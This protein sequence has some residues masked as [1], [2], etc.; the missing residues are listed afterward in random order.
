LNVFDDLFTVPHVCSDYGYFDV[1]AKIAVR[2]PGQHSPLCWATPEV[3]VVD[4]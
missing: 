1:Q 2:T 4:L 3:R